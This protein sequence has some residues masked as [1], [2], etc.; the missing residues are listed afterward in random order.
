[1]LQWIWES[2]GTWQPTIWHVISQ[3]VQRKINYFKEEIHDRNILKCNNSCVGSKD[4]KKYHKAETSPVKKNIF[5]QKLATRLPIS[6]HSCQPSIPCWNV[7]WRKKVKVIHKIFHCPPPH[8]LKQPLLLL[9]SLSWGYFLTYFLPREVRRQIACWDKMLEC[10]FFFLFHLNF[11]L[12][13]WLSHSPG[14]LVLCSL[15]VAQKCSCFV[16]KL[17]VLQEFCHCL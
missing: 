1:M 3:V 5:L 4:R 15:S 10:H 2:F 13:L 8:K 16:R 9:L 7:I 11:T 17:K 12:S 14:Y 6:E